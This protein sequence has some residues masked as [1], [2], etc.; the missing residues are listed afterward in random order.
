MSNNNP[1]NG[2]VAFLAVLNRQTHAIS[3]DDLTPWRAPLL[4]FEAIAV[5]FKA[6]GTD[7]VEDA[8]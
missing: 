7:K 4:L 6:I 5:V 8:R 2:R 1:L 3:K